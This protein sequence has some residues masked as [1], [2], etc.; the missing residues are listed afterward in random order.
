VR[1]PDA[2]GVLPRQG[3]VVERE[4]EVGLEGLVEDADAVAG[5]E[6]DAFVVLER[7]EED[8]EG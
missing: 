8:R 6:E 4:V 1:L 7:A 3:R 5:E 2:A